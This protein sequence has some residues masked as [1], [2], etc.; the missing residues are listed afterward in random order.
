MHEREF[1]RTT[2]RLDT[3]FRVVEGPSIEA[4]RNKLAEAPSVWAPEGERALV[5]L[6][7]STSTGNDAL[8]ARAILD[9]IRQFRRLRTSVRDP[10]GPMEVGLLTQLSGGGA[11]LET[12]LELDPGACLDMRLLDDE[13]EPPPVRVLA[14]V[15]HGVGLPYGAYGVAFRAIHPSDRDRLVR[16]TYRLQRRELRRAGNHKTVSA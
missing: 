8:L 12:T 11:R 15:I 5:D 1:A 14:E 2:V 4:L 7:Q 13:T 6:A 10:G 16:Y 9:L 3:R